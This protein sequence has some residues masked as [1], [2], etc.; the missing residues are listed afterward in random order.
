VSITNSTY[1]F[2]G[3]VQADGRRYVRETHTDHLGAL[4]LISYLAAVGADYSSIMAA[5]VAQ[6]EAGLADLEY[7]NNLSNDALATQH[8]TKADLLA[9]FREAYR[10]ASKED[11]ARLATWVIRRV[12]QGDVTEAQLQSAFGLTD[13]Q[14]ATLRAK[15]L[16]LRDHWVAV[17]AAEGE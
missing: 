6:I 12:T 14:Y 17:Q 15:M 4:H 1:E 9:K 3:P 10:S 8:I 16:A 5:R 11:L 7:A 13:P 2:D